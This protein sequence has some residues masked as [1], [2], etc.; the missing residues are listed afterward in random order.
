MCWGRQLTGN[1][2]LKQRRVHILRQLVE[3]ELFWHMDL[4]FWANCPWILWMVSCFRRASFNFGFHLLALSGLERV[5][6]ASVSL[7]SDPPG[8]SRRI[9]LANHKLVHYS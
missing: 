9:V 6:D 1:T 7:L 8:D 4:S 2:I 3:D 5:L